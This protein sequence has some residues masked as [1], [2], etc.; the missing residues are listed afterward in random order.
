MPNRVAIFIDGAYLDNVLREEFQ[1]VQI[2]YQS[3]SNALAE[4]SNI[5][6]TYYYHCPAY[7]GPLPLWKSAPGMRAKDD[8][9]R[10]WK[11]SLGTR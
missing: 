1:N 3:L 4:K 10:L 7:Q 9:L 5:L 2:D 8:S 11:G 6:R